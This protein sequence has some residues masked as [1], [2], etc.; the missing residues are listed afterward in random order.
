LDESRTSADDAAA[1]TATPSDATAI[2]LSLV[3]RKSFCFLSSPP[4][5]LYYSRHAAIFL[6]FSS[7]F[8]QT[9]LFLL[10]K[11]ISLAL[12]LALW[13]VLSFEGKSLGL[14][15]RSIDDIRVGSFLSTCDGLFFEN[16]IE[17]KMSEPCVAA[18]AAR[19]AFHPF[20]YGHAIF[21]LFL[22]HAT[23]SSYYLQ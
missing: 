8:P 11:R 22:A 4:F 9:F 5:V 6:F 12:A 18:R 15:D 10:R 7:P 14:V 16:K 13:L 19:L 23:F 3:M 1:A 17:S 2:I 20:A 21:E